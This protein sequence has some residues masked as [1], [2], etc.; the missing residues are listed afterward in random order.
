MTEEW[1][2]EPGYG[3]ELIE[4]FD[5]TFGQHARRRRELIGHAQSDIANMMNAAF[6]IKWHQ[7][8][9]S[10]IES[11]ERAIKLREALALATMYW[12]PIEDLA[13]GARLDRELEKARTA[14]PGH[15]MAVINLLQLNKLLKSQGSV[16]EVNGEHSEEA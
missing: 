10:K 3:R 4:T 1:L 12:I 2:E 9:I 14:R 8:V 13:T 7:T 5:Q 11:G 16:G 15:P 6:G